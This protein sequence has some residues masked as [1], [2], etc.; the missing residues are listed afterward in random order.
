[1]AIIKQ[2]MV[3]GHKVA[4]VGDGVNDA[5]ALAFADVGIGMG[6]GAD[7]AAEEADIVLITNDLLK[8]AE[9]VRMS[10]RSYRTIMVNFYGTVLVDAIGVGLAFLGLLNPLLAAGIHVGSELTFI[11]NSARLIWS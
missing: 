10:K 6:A 4:M 1:V 7:V 2:L 9:V 11:S 3:S 8:V 5:P